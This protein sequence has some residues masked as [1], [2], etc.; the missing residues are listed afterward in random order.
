MIEGLTTFDTAAVIAIL[1]M[2]IV[3][4]ATRA[5]GFWLM[6]YVTL[7]PMPRLAETVRAAVR[8]DIENFGVREIDQLLAEWAEPL[9]AAAGASSPVAALLALLDNHAG[10]HKD[11]LTAPLELIAL[12]CL[13]LRRGKYRV[14]DP[15]AHRR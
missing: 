3:T 11:L 12:A 5:G 9:C 15:V 4:Y 2:G 14:A 1:G 13:T 8:G 7:S 10:E 6:G